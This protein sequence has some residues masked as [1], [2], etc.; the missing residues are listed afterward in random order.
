MC[1]TPAAWC[2]RSARRRPPRAG[3]TWCAARTICAATSSDLKSAGIRV[4]LFIEPDAKAVEAAARARRAG[5]RA[6]HRRL[7]RARA[8]GRR[9]GPGARA[10]PARP[11]GALGG[12]GGP[13]GACRPRPH[14]QHG[15][16]PS[17]ASP[18]SSSS[19]SATSWSARR[20]SAG[21]PRPIA[22]MRA[23]MDEARAGASRRPSARGR[24]GDP[25]PRQRHHRHPP[26]REDHR[27]L[28]RALSCR[29]SSPTRSAGNRMAAPAAPPPTPSASRPRRP[30]PRRWEPGSGRACSGA[31]WGSSTWRSGRP[32]MVLTGGAAEQLQ[33]H[34]A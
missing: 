12:G 1:P 31:T 16:R 4:S 19:T 7:L 17:P 5:G 28:R 2:R 25:R 22:R 18:R 33:A 8:G 15:R 11:R 6:A 29:V 20:S 30:A 10:R 3:S 14:L 21:L 34:H 23:L 26:H 9:R 13:R 24:P 27:A 32:T